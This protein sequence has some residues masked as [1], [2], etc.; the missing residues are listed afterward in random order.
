M[1]NMAVD[2]RSMISGDFSRDSH[3]DA[4]DGVAQALK[5]CSSRSRAL[6]RWA[7]LVAMESLM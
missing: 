7:R 2:Y 6:S 4:G 1:D 3:A 5:A